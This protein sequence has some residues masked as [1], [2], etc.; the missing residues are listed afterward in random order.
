MYD[1]HTWINLEIRPLKQ[2]I[3]SMF[4]RLLKQM[5]VVVIWLSLNQHEPGPSADPMLN[6]CPHNSACWHDDE[7]FQCVPSTLCPVCFS[8]PPTLHVPSTTLAI[9]SRKVKLNCQQQN[10]TSAANSSW[11]APRQF[12]SVPWKRSCSRLSILLVAPQSHY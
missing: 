1:F 8:L 10:E 3:R 7:V 4:S 12:S 11:C 6:S 9:P 5:T 2:S